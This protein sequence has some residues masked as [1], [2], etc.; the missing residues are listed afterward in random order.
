MRYQ[1]LNQTALRSFQFHILV[2]PFGCYFFCNTSDPSASRA[3]IR[4][5]DYPPTLRP[6]VKY[7]TPPLFL[8]VTKTCIIFLFT[9]ALNNG[10]QV[11]TK[12]VVA[13]R[14]SKTDLIPSWTDG[15]TVLPLP[16]LSD[17]RV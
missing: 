11:T 6:L 2:I 3:S 4:I 17:E 16:H 10:A 8:T 15:G 1:E 9:I 12:R 7:L 5:P 13:S 14:T